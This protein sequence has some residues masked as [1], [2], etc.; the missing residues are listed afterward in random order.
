MSQQQPIYF[1]K[2]D[3]SIDYLCGL[4]AINNIFQNE[5]LV[6]D[7]PQKQPWQIDLKEKCQQFTNLQLRGLYASFFE[8]KNKER[9]RNGEQQLDINNPTSPEEL[10]VL[11]E[12]YN[13]P[14]NRTLPDI[15]KC[16]FDGSQKGNAPF[17]LLYLILV[18]DLHFNCGDGILRFGPNI[19]ANDRK[20]QIKLVAKFF[21]FNEHQLIREHLSDQLAYKIIEA[22]ADIDILKVA[23]QK[24]E[25]L[26]T[27]K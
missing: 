24:I 18:Q 3:T 8:A 5:I 7:N 27:K 4:Y 6:W 23:E 22:E 14:E 17:E 13:D 21:K 16:V 2:Q 20:E 19:N 9:E 12:Y 15:N 25:Y 11:K 10:A 1:V 26:K